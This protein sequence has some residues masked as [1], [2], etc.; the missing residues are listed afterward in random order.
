MLVVPWQGVVQPNAASTA[1]QFFTA[2]YGQLGGGNHK[3]AGVRTL[4][5]FLAISSFGN[6]VVNTFT[7]ARGKF[8]ILPDKHNTPNMP[9]SPALE[10]KADGFV[11]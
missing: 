11:Q 2:T 4:N 7:A 8:S 10:P 3:E 6:I 9:L 1:E 5:A